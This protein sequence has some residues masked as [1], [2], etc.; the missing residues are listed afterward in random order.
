MPGAG[1]EGS[2][3]C[4][5]KIAVRVRG[6]CPGHGPGVVPRRGPAQRRLE[7]NVPR[8]QRAEV[9]SRQG[10]QGSPYR[11]KGKLVDYHDK[12]LEVP[13]GEYVIGIQPEGS[14]PSHAWEISLTLGL[15]E[16]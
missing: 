11:F 1:G 6:H 9:A 10:R 15:G 12:A 16:P 7:R 8:H 4:K 14:R 3:S 2:E 5:V 13:A